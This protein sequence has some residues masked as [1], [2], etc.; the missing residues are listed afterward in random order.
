MSSDDDDD[1]DRHTRGGGEVATTTAA[2]IVK[3]SVAKESCRPTQRALGFDWTFFKLSSHFAT[4]DEAQTQ[5]T[6]KPVPVATY[7]GC[8]YIIDHHHTLVRERG[9]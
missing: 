5:M 6:R 7:R 9:V 2:T 3:W 8:Q 4:H 1:D